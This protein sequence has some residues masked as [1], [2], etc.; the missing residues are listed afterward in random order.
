M[1]TSGSNSI[2]KTIAYEKVQMEA[3]KQYN[4]QQH[5]NEQHDEPQQ[6]HDEKK[7]DNP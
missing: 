2:F 7:S 1:C 3:L 6:H 5:H 4:Q